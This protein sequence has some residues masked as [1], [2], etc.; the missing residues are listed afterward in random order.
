MLAMVRFQLHINADVGI[1]VARKVETSQA[2]HW[3]IM[4]QNKL[5]HVDLIYF[6]LLDRQKQHH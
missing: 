6:N 3:N 2:T 4:Q 1:F 5:L